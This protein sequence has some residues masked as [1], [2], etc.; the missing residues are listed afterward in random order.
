MDT[1]DSPHPVPL[2]PG[3]GGP[4]VSPE[5]APRSQSRISPL[6]WGAL[7]AALVFRIVTALMGRGNADGPGLVHWQPLPTQSS[8]AGH[9]WP[10]EPQLA[11]SFEKSAHPPAHRL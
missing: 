10:H 6:L 5:A 7:A 2:P 4:R 1:T 11:E 9:A 8:P 3:E